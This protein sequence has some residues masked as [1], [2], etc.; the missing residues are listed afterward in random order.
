[1]GHARVV[2]GVIGSVAPPEP[3][4]RHAEGYE[5]VEGRAPA[6]IDH[7]KRD[8]WLRQRGA[9]R[10]ACAAHRVGQCP[11]THGEP[12]LYDRGLN[13]I[14]RRVCDA[15]EKSHHN[16]TGDDARARDKDLPGQPPGQPGGDHPDDARTAERQ[17]G[18]QQLAKDAARQLTEG[19]SPDEGR[20]NPPHLDFTDA[21]L[22][23]HELSGHMNV[24]AHQIR[25]EA[26]QKE[27]AEKA[28]A[29]WHQKT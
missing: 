20:I 22:G 7:D 11:V 14:D 15:H 9:Q 16:Q 5:N 3:K 24:L 18:P 1:M 29:R 19:I 13:G 28:P 2:S 23:H 26:Q 4:Q 25:E 10:E 8:Q 27:Q 17:P 21:Q 6:P 12:A